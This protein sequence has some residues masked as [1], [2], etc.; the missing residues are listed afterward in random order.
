MPRP[1]LR[2]RAVDPGQRPAVVFDFLLVN[3]QAGLLDPEDRGGQRLDGQPARAGRAIGANAEPI[4]PMHTPSDETGFIGLVEN[5]QALGLDFRLDRV[6]SLAGSMPWLGR[7]FL[8]GTVNA[9]ASHCRWGGLF[10][11]LV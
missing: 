1:D 10:P 3:L 11:V 9:H 5:I 8:A 6:G 4:D 2:P 7:L